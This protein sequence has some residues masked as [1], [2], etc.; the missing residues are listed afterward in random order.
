M[1]GRT[2]GGRTKGRC[3]RS[4]LVDRPVRRARDWSRARCRAV[5]GRAFYP[6]WLLA[7]AALAGLWPAPV[8][9]APFGPARSARAA[10]GAPRRAPGP[11]RNISTGRN[12]LALVSQSAWVGP[13]AGQFQLHLAVR[14][15]NKAQETLAVI[16]YGRL[17]ARSQFQAAVSGHVYGPYYQGPGEGNSP[18][19]LDNL[20]SDPAGGVDVYIPVNAPS[21][22]LSFTT[23]GVYPVQAFLEEN[24]VRA[25]QPL[26]T[27]I[28]YV[29]KDASTLQP[30][31]TVLVVPLAARVPIDQAGRPGQVPA[32]VA[33]ALEA[34]A[35]E[36][37]LWH[38][39]VTIRPDVVTIESLASGSAAGRDAVGELKEAQVAGDELLPTTRLPV[40]VG[41]LV[42]AGLTGDLQAELSSGAS[43]LFKLLGEAPSFSTW[44]FSGEV[45]TASMAALAGMGATQVA[46]PDGDLS[47]LPPADN[48]LTFSQPTEL[49][50]DGRN[51]RAMGADS[52]LS[53]RT[54]QASVPGQ[55]ALVASQV[56][57]ELAMVDLEAPGD[58]H[59]IV[60]APPPGTVL[61]PGFLSVV[62]A[63]LRGNPLLNAV[64]LAQLF[65]DVPLATQANGHPLVRQLEGAQGVAPLAGTEL[66]A[67]ARATVSADSELYGHGSRLVGRLDQQLD[68]S[69]SAAFLASQRAAMI[70]SV[71]R[72]AESDLSK[73]RLPPSIS[74]TLTSRQGRLPLTL[75]SSAGTPVRVLLTLTSEQLSFV[76]VHF[77]N[78]GS[79]RP[80]NPGSEDCQLILS[81]ATTTLQVPVIVRT[82]GAF[83]LAL[84]LATPSGS[85]EIAAGTDTVR[86]T[87]ISGVGLILM[88]SAAL[89]LAVWWA[90]NARHGR[91]ARRLVPKPGDDEVGDI[92]GLASTAEPG[93]TV[94]RAS[95]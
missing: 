89:F 53:A 23:T 27:F 38:V 13:G 93:Q 52:E 40:D 67:T 46:V 54:A 51:V 72:T 33:S 44:A 50:L 69:L 1:D 66:L 25:G 63:G 65:A 83:P 16:V 47:A 36:L 41:A 94:A 10:P 3:P 45:N 4:Q 30:L 49:A 77:G 29:G 78:V 61:A 58:Q 71:L 74:I 81:R 9:A 88:V 11:G 18:V 48:K 37:Y 75:L 12:A 68:L 57:A 85:E 35:A 17:T 31:D 34:D 39:P 64:P 15:S 28:V 43:S 90:R 82:S 60:L 76:V 80:V 92:D 20:V 55:T 91:R 95:R 8:H 32:A 22:G 73:V 21:G 59:G 26:T 87:A 5:P 2:K 19:P 70:G 62:L 24:G 7:I 6:V 79:C 14:A 86:S 84:Q 42:S 56:L